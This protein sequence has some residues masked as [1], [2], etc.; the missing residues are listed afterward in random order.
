MS[1]KSI[2]PHPPKSFPFPF[3]HGFVKKRHY[4]A[5]FLHMRRALTN[6]FASCSFR[7]AAAETSNPVFLQGGRFG[8]RALKNAARQTL[9]NTI[10]RD[11][12]PTMRSMSR[13]YCTRHN[14]DTEEGF[15]AKTWEHARRSAR[16]GWQS[17]R[18]SNESD[19]DEDDGIKRVEGGSI[20]GVNS[21]P[22]PRVIS[23]RDF[24]GDAW[25]HARGDFAGRSDA[26]KDVGKEHV[27]S[28]TIEDI[29]SGENS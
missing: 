9:Q 16:E 29:D 23:P 11:D 19:A 5:R 14:D 17:A 22:P 21:T 27:T 7:A 4:F 15:A 28:W 2:N 10:V 20:S 8:A 26:R 25:M 3:V 24:A 13:A 12:A 1:V 6:A 18:D